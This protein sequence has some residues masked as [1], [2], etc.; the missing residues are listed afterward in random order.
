MDLT[1]GIGGLLDRPVQGAADAVTDVVTAGADAVSAGVDAVVTPVRTRLGAGV[2]SVVT[3]GHPP[4]RDLGAAGDTDPGLFGPGS[5]T[6]R[7][8][9]DPAMFI[10]GLRA[11][12]L[13]TMHPLAMAGVADHS[14]YRDDP[15]GRLRRTSL[16]VATTTYGTTAQAEAAIAGV[17]RAHRSVVGVAPDG[18]PY[19]ASDP[20]LITWIHHAEV[21]SFLRT[22]QRYGAR[23]LSPAE[24]D[25]YV[26]EM[27][28]LCDR[29]GGEAPA[30]SVAELDAYFHA[31]RH[32]LRATGQAREAARWLMVPPLPLAARPAYAVIAPAAVGL[33]PGWVRRQLWLPLLPGVDP[34]LV[35]P[36]AR[37][38]VRTLDWALSGLPDTAAAHVDR[39]GADPSGRA[40][41]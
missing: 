30:R 31:V 26:D 2:R 3:G 8:H 29:L 1:L 19:A 20:H 40:A 14:D 9:A 10:A 35:Q 33:L 39:G 28:E 13:Q 38:L 25:R 6:W 24:A 16:F 12:L 32:E 27:A 18:R 15:M 5:V 21:D 23:P 37:A 34:L 17:E 7:V 11:L 41:A 36:S 22:H 4:I